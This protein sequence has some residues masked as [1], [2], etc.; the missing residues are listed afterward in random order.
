MW[1]YNQKPVGT[2]IKI[3]AEIL[4]IFETEQEEGPNNEY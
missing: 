4:L 2:L 3:V 1:P